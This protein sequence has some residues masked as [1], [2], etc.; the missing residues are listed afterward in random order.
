[1]IYRCEYC[2]CQFILT[3]ASQE[4]RFVPHFC[5]ARCDILWRAETKRTVDELTRAD[6]VAWVKERA[7]VR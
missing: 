4:D 3:H 2:G 1:M 6:A 5:G 7:S